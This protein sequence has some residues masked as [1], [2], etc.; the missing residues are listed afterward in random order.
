LSDKKSILELIQERIVILDGA[1]G[2]A[3]IAAGLPAGKPPESWNIERPQIIQELQKNYFLSGSD[4]ILT[5]TF[6]GTRVKL[7]KHKHGEFVEEYN[8]KAVENAR[9]ICP[10]NGYVAGDIGPTGE[11]LPPVG[12]FTINGFEE[13]FREQAEFLTQ[14]NVDFFFVETM[15]DIKEAEAA[16]KAI[17]RNSDMPIFA[18]ITYQKTK[19][20]YFTIMGNTVEQCVKSLEN[21]GANVIGGNCTIGS[22]EMVD[23][24]PLLKQQTSLPISV[25]PNAG[26]PELIDGNTI[27]PT[28]PKDFAKDILQM[29]DKGAK[30][31]GGCCGTSPEYIKLIAQ[32]LKE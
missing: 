27:Y 2:S 8:K 14:A 17:R 32:K 10:K 5:N 24:V 29:V 9:A 13:T 1:M 20:G 21:A 3:L 6:G 25:K 11:F 26:R 15:V 31:V 28:T 7:G 12:K 23:L 22:D 19:R 4:A 16:V 18:S 30:I